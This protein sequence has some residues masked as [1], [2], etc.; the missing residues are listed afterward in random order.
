M[1]Q[2]LHWLG[3][4]SF[5]IQ[6]E[7]VIYIDPWKI[8][9]RSLSAD[10]ILITHSHYDHLSRDDIDRVRASH[11]E[12]LIP[13]SCASTFG[14]EARTI[15]PGDTIE[16]KG[17]KIEAVPAYNMKTGFHPYDNGWLGYIIHLPEGTVYHAGDTDFIP[18]MNSLDVDIALLPIGGTFTMTPEAAVE[19]AVAVKASI[20]VPMHWGEVS[21]NR[22][23]AERFVELACA[24]GIDA[25]IMNQE[26]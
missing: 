21:G 22:A 19:A 20:A 23:S 13:E 2:K 26:R 18:E 12:I 1:F 24:K 9:S 6:S 3:H 11:T 5:R 15:V 14:Q 10:L 16:I 8:A 7:S 4:S 17:V 25:R